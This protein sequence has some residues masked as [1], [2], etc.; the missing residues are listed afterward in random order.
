MPPRIDCSPRVGRGNEERST[1]MEIQFYDV[2]TRQKVGVPESEVRKTKFTKD[3][4]DGGT[5]TTYALR[6]VHEGRKLMKFASKADWE[7]LAVPEE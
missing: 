7:S 3:T 5:R 2:K 6:A 4:K 1:T